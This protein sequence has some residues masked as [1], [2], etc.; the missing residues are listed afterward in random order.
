MPN[1]PMKEIEK[2]R[3]KDKKVLASLK[4]KDNSYRKEL[5]SKVNRML[6]ETKKRV[7]K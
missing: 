1:D 2:I 6:N 7:K 3:K 5:D 4:D